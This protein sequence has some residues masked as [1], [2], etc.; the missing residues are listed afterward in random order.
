MF[1]V[2]KNNAKIGKY[3]SN[4]I[5]QKYESKRA[6]CCAYI[7]AAGEEPTNENLN[8]MSNRLSQ[9]IKGNKSIQTY[10]LPYF[11][12]LLGISCEQ[13]LSAGEYIVPIAN[14]VTN[15]SIA[16]SKDSAEW[17]KYIKREDK[18][19]LNCDEYCKTVLDYALEFGNY[20]FIKYLMDNKYIWFDSRKDND[21][22]QTFGAG[23]SIER[24]QISSVDYGLEGKLKTEDELRTNLIALAADNGDIEMLNNLRA[25]ENP[26]LYLRAHFLSGQHPDFESCNNERMLKHIAAS[27]NKILDYFTDSF[28]IRDNVRYKDGSERTH[29]F[30]FP[31]ISKLL[32]LL[33]T[34]KS[35]F[36]QTALT[37]ALEYNN[38]TYNKLCKLILAVKNDERYAEEYMKVLWIKACRQELAF[39]E[40]GDIV[41]FSA[42]Y[43][44]ANDK[45]HINGIITNVPHIT[46]I[47]S[48]HELRQLAEELNES[49]E[50]IKN[51]KE[52]LEEIK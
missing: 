27:S 31:Y 8:N 10:D 34:A 50:K 45:N 48:S 16:G 36:A 20:D 13:I 32:D 24:R 11:T 3:L 47:P 40:N 17:E 49:Y 42:I 35:N 9:I 7:C 43:S 38:K 23:T 51:I 6:F 15:Y 25:R 28:E 19:I 1:K 2:E 5:E 52:H 12:D 30:M 29:T 26:Q 21:Y 44:T 14:R 33:I 22:A 41:M 46:K 4:L 39:Y 18:L 37:K